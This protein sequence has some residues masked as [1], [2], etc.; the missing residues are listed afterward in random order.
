MQPDHTDELTRLLAERILVL[1]GAM[2]TKIQQC[3]LT[4]R[5]FRGPFHDHP[6]DLAGDND[7]LSVTQPQTVDSI[8]FPNAHAIITVTGT[9]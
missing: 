6:R 1:D 8:G 2:G 7:V 9:H 4:E 3:R 5:D